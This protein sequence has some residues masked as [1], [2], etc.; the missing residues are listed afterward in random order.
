M[1]RLEINENVLNNTTRCSKNFAC[2]S[3]NGQCL[4]KLTYCFNGKSYFIKPNGN[5]LCTY[6]VS[7]AGNVLCGCPTRKEIYNRYRI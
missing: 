1:M 7:F 3:G 4:C 6:K 2:L 5:L